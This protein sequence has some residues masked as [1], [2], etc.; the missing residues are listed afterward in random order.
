VVAAV[1]LVVQTV[2]S[3]D[4]V[5]VA[6]LFQLVKTLPSPLVQ[7]FITTLEQQELAQRLPIQAEQQ[8]ATLG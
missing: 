3:V 2:A 8:V 7:L 6:V 1:H 5:A 4:L